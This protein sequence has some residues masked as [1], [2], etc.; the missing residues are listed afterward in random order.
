MDINTI[1]SRAGL[2][3]VSNSIN[4]ELCL[5]AIAQEWRIEFFTEWGHRWIDLKRTGR[6]NAV[7]SNVKNNW[8]YYD[9]LYPIP[10]SELET[11][12]NLEQNTG[13]E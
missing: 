4:S 2:P 10:V 11:A 8:Q 13:Y 9:T 1:R 3:D 7:L 12:P 5:D 6:A